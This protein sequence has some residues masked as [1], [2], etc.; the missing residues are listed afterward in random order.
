MRCMALLSL[1]LL[2]SVV[3]VQM[4]PGVGAAPTAPPELATVVG[5][6]NPWLC[7]ASIIGGIVSVGTGSVPGA[8]VS[9]AGITK[10]C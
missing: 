8:I 7:A 5:G 4:S 3:T 10:F 9:G 1:M 2:L 6:R